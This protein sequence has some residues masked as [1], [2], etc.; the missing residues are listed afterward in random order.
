MSIEYQNGASEVSAWAREAEKK[1]GCDTPKEL[2]IIEHIEGYCNDL[3]N[4]RGRGCEMVNLDIVQ[5]Q[6]R[7]YVSDS[8]YKTGTTITVWDYENAVSECE[9]LWEDS[10]DELFG[11]ELLLLI[12]QEEDD[13]FMIEAKWHMF[14]S[15]LEAVIEK[16]EA[17]AVSD[18]D[19]TALATSGAGNV[20]SAMTAE[21]PD[22]AIRVTLV[23]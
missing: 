3:T 19:A 2:A 11:L 12:S 17:E 10:M 6:V 7:H 1:P 9:L 5:A 4:T 15:W 22:E 8:N 23:K 20:Q 16:A 18:K 13:A 21:T 14:F